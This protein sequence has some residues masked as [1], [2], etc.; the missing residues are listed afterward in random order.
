MYIIILIK[1]NNMENK[2][3]PK[4]KKMYIETEKNDNI[5]K[6]LNVKMLLKEKI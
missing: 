2:N 6:L 1:V 5:R 3:T 4:N